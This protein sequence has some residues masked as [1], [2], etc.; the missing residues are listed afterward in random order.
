MTNLTLPAPDATGVALLVTGWR[1]V[2]KTTLLLR[3]R[4]AAREAG[5]RVGGF[6]SVAR[7]ADGVKTG[8]DLIDAATGQSVPLADYR[9]STADAGDA[10][11][12]RHYVFH[13]PAL[14]AGL[15]YAR[16]GSRADVFFVDELGPLELVR[17]QGWADVMPLIVARAYGVALVVVRPELVELARDRLALPADAPRLALDE[18]NRDALAETVAAWLRRRA[19]GQADRMT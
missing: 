8:I 14:E 12:T 7:F 5:L 6:L 16:A 18:A 9:E 19:P 2:G 15:R 1:G 3:A 10:V 11:H 17:G 13:E 4:D